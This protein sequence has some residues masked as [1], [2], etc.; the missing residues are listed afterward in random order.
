MQF[1][2]SKQKQTVSTDIVARDIELTDPLRA[3][4]SEKIEKTIQKLGHN[5]V[6]SASV[7]LRVIKYPLTGSH[8][9]SISYFLQICET[10]RT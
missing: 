8:L 10:Y 3:R 2:I 4:V 9:K 6:L 1:S 7:I 5:D